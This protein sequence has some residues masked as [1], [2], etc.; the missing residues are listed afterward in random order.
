MLGISLFLLVY[1]T[2]CVICTI[3]T[4]QKMWETLM[5]ECTFSKVTKSNFLKRVFFML[6][7]LYEWNQIV[8][9]SVSASVNVLLW[10]WL[11]GLDGTNADFDYNYFSLHNRTIIGHDVLR[12]YSENRLQHEKKK[13][14]VRFAVPNIEQL[15]FTNSKWFLMFYYYS[16]VWQITQKFSHFQNRINTFFTAILKKC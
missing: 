16:T 4:V 5:E 14:F 2:L 15:L 7:K 11:Q 9:I 3:C 10:N 8:Q 12:K 13:R 6:F 1:E